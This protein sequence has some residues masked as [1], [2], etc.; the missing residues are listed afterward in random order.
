MRGVGFPTK[1]E[2]LEE[3]ICPAPL[4]SLGHNIVATIQQKKERNQELQG[5][6]DIGVDVQKSASRGPKGLRKRREIM[7]QG[8]WYE[9]KLEGFFR[10][11][12]AVFRKTRGL[13]KEKQ[14]LKGQYIQFSCDNK[15]WED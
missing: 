1:K 11:L 9:R 4:S 10:N 15:K 13:K 5:Q 7:A 6:G 3:G 14:S 2:M 12:L 8:G